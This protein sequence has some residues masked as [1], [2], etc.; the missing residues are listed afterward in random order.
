M[1]LLAIIEKET[2]A[3]NQWRRLIFCE[4]LSRAELFATAMILVSETERLALI[5]D[6]AG[7]CPEPFPTREEWL[8]LRRLSVED[9]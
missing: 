8:R 7:I 1:D 3:P 2:I 4:D 5:L 6:N 9:S